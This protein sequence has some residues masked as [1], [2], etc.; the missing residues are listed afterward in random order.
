MVIPAGVRRAARTRRRRPSPAPRRARTSPVAACGPGRRGDPPGPR[1]RRPARPANTP[2]R[3]STIRRGQQAPLGTLLGARLQAP[4]TGDAAAQ[5]LAAFNTALVRPH[6][7]D[8][9]PQ[10]GKFQWD[11][12]ERLV[13]VV[14][15]EEP[16]ALHGPAGAD[17]QAR[18]AR[19]AVP[20][21]R[22][23]GGAGLGPEVRRGG[24]QAL[25]RQGP[26]LARRRPA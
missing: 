17:R 2:S 3:C 26:A 4:P 21:R 14:P 1:R 10:V 7:P 6:W 11:A 12:T 18:A 9:E 15:R 8:L 25:P 19:L 20:R 24:G 16:A 13:A 5:F 23:R 22:L